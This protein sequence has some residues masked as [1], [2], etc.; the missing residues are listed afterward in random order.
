LSALPSNCRAKKGE[1]RYTT[2]PTM[3]FPEEEGSSPNLPWCTEQELTSAGFE[4]MT[5]EGPI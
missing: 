1:V 5:P 3:A 4:K 2:F